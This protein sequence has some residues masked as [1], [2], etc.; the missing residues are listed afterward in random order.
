[1]RCVAASEQWCRKNNVTV[2]AAYICREKEKIRC[3]SAEKASLQHCYCTSLSLPH[4]IAGHHQLAD[5][6]I[7]MQYELADRLSFFLCGRKPMHSM[8]EHFL[9]PNVAGR[10]SLILNNRGLPTL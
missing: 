7:E 5:R 2:K 10:Y 1:M 8:G 9:V 6:L 4:R 3:A